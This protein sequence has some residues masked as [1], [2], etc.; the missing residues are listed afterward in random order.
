MVRF[1]LSF[2]ERFPKVPL[3][4]GC[5]KENSPNQYSVLSHHYSN[6]VFITI[7]STPQF[8]IF[9]YY[10]FLCFSCILSHISQIIITYSAIS[11]IFLRQL[12]YYFHILAMIYSSFIIPL[13]RQFAFLRLVVLD[14]EFVPFP[15]ALQECS[16]SESKEIF[17]PPWI[18]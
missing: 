17:T 16:D 9:Q 4:K 15:R 7:P 8:G 2:P 5:L 14:E 3:E 10:H 12:S 13:F 11:H 1:D 18:I 6:E